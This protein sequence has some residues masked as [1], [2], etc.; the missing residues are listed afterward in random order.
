MHVALHAPAAQIGVAPEHCALV[1][2][3]VAPPGSQAPFTHVEP[4]AHW[5]VAHDT[6]HSPLSQ[7]SPEGHWLSNWQALLAAVHA[8][9]TQTWL[10]V[11]SVFAV[12]AHGPRVPP[13]AGPAS[14]PAS[15][16]P[17]LL[18]PDEPELAP[19]DDPELEPEDEPPLEEP[20][21]A[22][23]DELPPPDPDPLLAVG[24]PPV[25]EHE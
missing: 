20:E 17:P 18:P 21:L 4:L 7:T 3:D 23:P 6:R 10:A 24:P 11:H 9:A 14:V 25:S 22:T 16:V 2:H 13:Q 1:V 8:P 12:H 19:E 5:A 15:T